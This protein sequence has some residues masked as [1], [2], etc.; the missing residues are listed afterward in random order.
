MQTQWQPLATAP[1]DGTRI[2]VLGEADD[3]FIVR[4][5]DGSQTG[6][7]TGW[8]STIFVYESDELQGWTPIPS[9]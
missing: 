6:W 1:K 4:W 5:Q 3:V 7:P 2:L 8:R 9:R